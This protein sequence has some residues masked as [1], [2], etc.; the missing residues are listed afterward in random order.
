MIAIAVSIL[1]V[2]KIQSLVQYLSGGGAASLGDRLLWLTAW[3]GLNAAS[4]FET[5]TKPPR[6]TS[7]EWT[8]AATNTLL[9]GALII[10]VAPRLVEV[11]DLAGGWAA[12]IG[13]IFLFHFGSLHLVAL[14]WRRIGRN[15]S[16]IMNAP[17]MATSLSEFW[18]R[19]WN[20]AFRD[21][22]QVCVFRP[23]AKKWNATAAMWVGFAFSGLVH[24]LAISVPA[25]AGFGLP[26]G[27]FLLQGVG[28]SVERHAA[29]RGLPVRG[30]M[31]GWLYAA[32]FTV[33]A[34]FWLFHPPFVR[35]VV[36]PL[37]GH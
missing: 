26:M 6:P 2:V 23:V 32:L 5:G 10:C 19:R 29:R 24:E 9:G 14:A 31:C 33:P 13:I 37:I 20:I 11:N 36:L 25:G 15:V 12:M 1:L 30:G 8:A 21:F 35:N 7:R 27:Y 34:A 16:P 28:V 18:S 22:S 3:P 17:V 4:F